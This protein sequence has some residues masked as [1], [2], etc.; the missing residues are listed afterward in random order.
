[1]A[2][3]VLQEDHL[4]DE[5]FSADTLSCLKTLLRT[6]DVAFHTILLANEVLRHLFSAF[7]GPGSLLLGQLPQNRLDLRLSISGVE[8]RPAKAHKHG[9]PEQQG[10]DG[11]PLCGRE[12]V[13]QERVEQRFPNEGQSPDQRDQTPDEAAIRTC[14][15]AFRRKKAAVPSSTRR[16]E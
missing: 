13:E 14:Q 3:H 5:W 9:P 2:A 7:T 12:V 4:N 11:H 10:V 1:M 8:G 6:P 16:V 15:V